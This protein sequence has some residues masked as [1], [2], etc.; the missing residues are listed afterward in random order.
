[1]KTK[2]MFAVPAFARKLIAPV[3]LLASAV[4]ASAAQC[5]YECPGEAQVCDSHTC[6]TTLTSCIID[7]NYGCSPANIS[8][9]GK[10]CNC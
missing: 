4:P 8:C 10:H 5:C 9:S 6:Y 7:C 3:G 1:M 2:L